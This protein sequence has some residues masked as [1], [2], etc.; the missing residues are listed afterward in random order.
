LKNV[1]LLAN[2]STSI[3][4]PDFRR[5]VLPHVAVA[6]PARG[7]GEDVGI[8]VSLLDRRVTAKAVYFQT[9]E[10]GSSTAGQGPFVNANTRFVDAFATV[11]VGPGR[12]LTQAEWTTRAAA[13]IPDISGVLFDTESSGYEFSVTAN[14]TRNWRFTAG[15]SYTDRVQA[16]TYSRDIVPWYGFKRENG[17]LQQGVRQNANGTFTVDPAA[18]ES[19]GTVATWLELSR[20]HPEANLSTL[21]SQNGISLAQELFNLIE[22]TNA[23]IRE[24]EQRWGLR[25]H[26][27]NMF[28]AYDFTDGPLKGFTIGGGYR[29]RSPNIIG[30][31]GGGAEMKGRAITATDAMLRYRRRLSE[32]RVKGSLTF[33]V[34]VMN[35]FNEGGIIPTHISSTT[36][37]IVPG[38]RGI[39]YSRFALVAPRSYRFTVTY[40]F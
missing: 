40:E 10:E 38:G 28:T 25:P 36:D 26:R 15:Y 20:L 23:D 35:V 2:A 8:S 13:L 5:K 3:A 37:F 39:G 14:P 17:L 21:T 32:G 31:S 33:Q 16:N 22:T 9:S 19:T 7:T 4:L 30:A 34:N 11:L 24:T 6:D 12:P 27:A 29:W 18:F 1:S